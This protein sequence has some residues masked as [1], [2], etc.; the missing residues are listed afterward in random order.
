MAIP[1]ASL[2]GYSALKA[3]IERELGFLREG[4][5][6]DYKRSAPWEDLQ[7]KIIKTCLG[8][9]NLRDGG[10]IVV[11]VAEEGVDWKVSGILPEHLKTFD[12]DRI[13]DAIN[14][15]ASR[16]LPVEI[17]TIEHDGVRLL[18]IAVGPLQGSPDLP[19]QWA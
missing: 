9:A 3:R 10:M 13:T 11:G 17:V 16:P 8:M 1:D 18:V 19:P 15:Y 5:S 4:R 2:A 14:R 6:I 12:V 7:W